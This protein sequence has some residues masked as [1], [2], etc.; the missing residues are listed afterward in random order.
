MRAS[1]DIPDELYRRVKAKTALEGRGVDDVTIELF[2]KWVGESER[3]NRLERNQ[4]WLEEFLALA[5]PADTPGPTARE[6][7]EQGRNRLDPTP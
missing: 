2:Q 4:Q 5:I 6:I 1:I 3:E 7:L